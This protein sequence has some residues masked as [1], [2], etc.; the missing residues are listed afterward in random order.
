NL[1]IFTGSA[2]CLVRHLFAYPCSTDPPMF[3]VAARSYHRTL[4]NSQENHAASGCGLN[5]TRF[6]AILLS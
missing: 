5:N 3:S 1:R 2:S 4:Q 6:V